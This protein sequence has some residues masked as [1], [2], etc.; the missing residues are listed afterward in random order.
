M[1]RIYPPQLPYA[2]PGRTYP[3]VDNPDYFSAISYTLDNATVTASAN[4]TATQLANGDIQID[5]AAGKTP[6]SNPTTGLTLAWLMRDSVTGKEI[7]FSIN[8]GYQGF[9][10]PWVGI[11]SGM[12]GGNG[13]EISIGTAASVDLLTGSTMAASQTDVLNKPIAS[14]R[15]IPPGT[16]TRTQDAGPTGLA[17]S[18]LLDMYKNVGASF[19]LGGSQPNGIGLTTL[20]PRLM[21]PAGS[22]FDIALG[23]GSVAVGKY[24]VVNIRNSALGN[25]AANRTYVIRPRCMAIDWRA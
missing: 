13:V 6:D 25:V 24:L 7:D 9:V 12:G 8:N 1:T 19:L 20:D 2:A 4:I 5:V 10:A 3:S 23:A 17:T 21:T 18:V 11:V 14:W 22:P 16:F 15:F